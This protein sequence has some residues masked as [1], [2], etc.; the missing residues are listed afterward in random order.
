MERERER[1]RERERER[2]REETRDRKKG[3]FPRNARATHDTPKAQATHTAVAV[4]PVARHR[5]RLAVP[6][7]VRE[8]GLPLL[9]VGDAAAVEGHPVVVDGNRG[10]AL[11]V[12]RVS[13]G[14]LDETPVPEGAL[15]ER[16]QGRSKGNS[17]KG[18]GGSRDWH[19]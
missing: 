13:R 9:D 7:G 18:L 19:D 8:L 17:G 15:R 14:G 12:G 1:K 4:K 3:Q 16:E 2:E 10:E 6:V 11:L 5:N